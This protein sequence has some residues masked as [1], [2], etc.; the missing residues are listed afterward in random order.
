MCSV[1]A[2]P[3]DYVPRSTGMYFFLSEDDYLELKKKVEKMFDVTKRTRALLMPL[4]SISEIHAQ[5]SY[6]GKV[7]K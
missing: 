1:S 7:K 6:L 3:R 2:L 5:Y 4:R